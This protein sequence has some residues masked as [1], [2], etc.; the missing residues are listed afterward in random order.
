MFFPVPSCFEMLAN[1][2]VLLRLCWCNLL[3]SP[4]VWEK[5]FCGTSSHF[6]FYETLEFWILPQ[7]GSLVALKSLLGNWLKIGCPLKQK[8]SLLEYILSVQHMYW[9]H[10]GSK[11]H[12][13]A[14]RS[15]KCRMELAFASLP[16]W[17][18]PWICRSGRK[19]SA[20]WCLNIRVLTNK[21]SQ[22]I[23]YFE[24]VLARE[25][26]RCTQD[27]RLLSHGTTNN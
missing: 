23:S 26:A 20:M 4:E 3:C 5:H 13:K 22:S 7:N 1:F 27:L 24:K 14:E 9:H 18:V 17:L 21:P 25:S 11:Q 6:K 10:I 2:T 16:V 15:W 12:I 19:G 8:T